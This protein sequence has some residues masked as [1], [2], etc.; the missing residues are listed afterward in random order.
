MTHEKEAHYALTLEF[1]NHAIKPCLAFT[2]QKEAHYAIKLTP[3]GLFS[4]LIHR[5]TENYKETDTLKGPCKNMSHNFIN[6]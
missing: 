2:P 1:S 4:S 3:E 5:N 6:S